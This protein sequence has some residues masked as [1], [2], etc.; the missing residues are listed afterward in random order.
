MFNIKVKQYI[1]QLAR[2]S[3]GHYLA[4]G[5]KLLIDESD[6][7]DQELKQKRSC[8]VTL[9]LD[10]KLR[11]CMGHIRPI[12]ELYLDII[13]NAVKA[14][15]EDPRF[16]PLTKDEFDNVD[17]EISILTEPQKLDFIDSQD[18][19]DKLRAGI[20]GVIISKGNYG[21]TYLPQV[22]EDLSSKKEF[23]SSLCLKAGLGADDWKN[24][25][26]EV[27]VYQICD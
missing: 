24:S 4:T 6:L 17:I 15:F 1:S 2:R 16:S 10:G 3:I 13:D 25:K 8:F 7:P 27:K 22:W 5:T 21:A 26:L 18:L 9:E 14:G 23:L 11:G 20:D 19:I 12:Q